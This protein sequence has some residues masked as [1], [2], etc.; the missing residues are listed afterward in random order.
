[1]TPYEVVYGVPPLRLLSYV[2]GTTR[3]EAV[4]DVLRNHLKRTERELKLGQGVYLRLQPYRQTPIAHRRA[5]KL[6]PRFYGPFRV[7]RKVGKVAYEIELLP[8]ARFHLV[9]HVSQLKPKLGSAVVPLPKLPPGDARGVLQPEPV[10]VLDRRSRPKNN[11]VL[12]EILIRWE[13]QT[14]D[15]ATWEEYHLLKD[16]YPHLVGEV[17]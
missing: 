6:S 15:D 12:V 9:F 3:V 17:F 8:E 13:G 11:R 1:M 4:D 10:E 5:L 2:P 7:L 16:A 14:S